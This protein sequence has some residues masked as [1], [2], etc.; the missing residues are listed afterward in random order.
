M[1]E[2]GAEMGDDMGMMEI[3]DDMGMDAEMGVPEME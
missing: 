2:M 1:M 3:G